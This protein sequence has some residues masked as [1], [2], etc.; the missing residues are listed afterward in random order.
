PKVIGK[1]IAAEGVA[2][3]F[4]NQATSSRQPSPPKDTSA[5]ATSTTSATPAPATST[6]SAT[7]AKLSGDKAQ[8]RA[9]LANL[10]G[11]G[12]APKPAT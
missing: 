8:A 4:Q 2:Q 3:I 1:V 12:A 9:A 5:T 10:F 7:P 6:T 11:G